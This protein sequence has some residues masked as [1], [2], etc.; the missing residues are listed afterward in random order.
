MWGEIYQAGLLFV[1][2]ATIFLKLCW[3]IIVNLFK[4]SPDIEEDNIN[5]KLN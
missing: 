3:W 4:R 2:A 1:F 5:A